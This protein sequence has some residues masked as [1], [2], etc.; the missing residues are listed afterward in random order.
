MLGGANLIEADLR[1]AD[2]TDAVLGGAD[3]TGAKLT[4]A[5]L[6]GA[7]L[8]GADLTGARWPEGAQ[9]PVGWMVDSGSGRL[10]RAGQ[11]QR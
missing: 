1:G 3:L 11:Y 4:R 2:L 8:R 7:V 9:V 5:Y 10:K 6:T